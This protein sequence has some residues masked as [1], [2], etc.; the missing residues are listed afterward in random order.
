VVDRCSEVAE[1]ADGRRREG[2][3]DVWTNPPLVDGTASRSDHRC[4]GRGAGDDSR[5]HHGVPGRLR[6]L[7]MARRVRLVWAAHFAATAA[8]AVATPAI[9]AGLSVQAVD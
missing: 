7:T 8:A 1:A 5:R 4:P 9:L 3:Q 6:D 2:A